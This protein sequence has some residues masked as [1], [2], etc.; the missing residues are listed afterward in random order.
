MTYHNLWTNLEKGSYCKVLN[1]NS[2]TKYELSHSQ[3]NL[4]THVAAY[5]HKESF[6]FLTIN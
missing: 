1:V 6:L 4:A 2:P 5:V 3:R